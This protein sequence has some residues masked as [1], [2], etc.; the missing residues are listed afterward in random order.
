Q[1]AQVRFQDGLQIGNLWLVGEWRR[2]LELAEEFIAECEAGSPHYQESSVRS[3]R[4]HHRLGRGDSD[5][6]PAD[7]ELGPALA[8][9][10]PAPQSTGPALAR[11]PHAAVEVGLDA[12]AR[13]LASEAIANTR[14]LPAAPTLVE[15]AWVA[16]TVGIDAELETILEPLR[17]M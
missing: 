3:V 6:A 4:A 11:L 17:P 16:S 10:V 9:E 1:H 2:S 15:L 14:A 5:G 12:R 13:E 7:A 8:R